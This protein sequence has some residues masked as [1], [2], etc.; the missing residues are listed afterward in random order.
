MRDIDPTVLT[1]LGARTI[2]ARNFVWL[3]GKDNLGASH[4]AGFWDEV[5][6]VT[7]SYVDFNTG[8]TSSRDYT[9]AGSL[10][11]ID[12]IALVND[13]SVRTITIG[14]S[15]VD[16]AVAD[17]VRG[18]NVRG[19]AIEVHRGLFNPGTYKLVAPLS[20]R[21]IGFIDT[22][23]ITDP[24]EGQSGNI[25][26]NVVSHT[27]ELTRINTDVCSDPSQKLRDSSD[28]FYKDIGVVGKWQIFWGQK[29]GSIGKSAVDS[30]P[31]DPVPN[32][33]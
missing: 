28:N 32:D 6:T 5:G 14:L 9:G 31:T 18:Y 23:T 13:V 3:T 29:R 4:S 2:K 17:A 15:Q 7:A 25:T 8:L 24:K 21:F 22:M 20:P 27:R 33:S 1:A 19:G 11:S 30:A 12:P 10:L 26:L 16:T